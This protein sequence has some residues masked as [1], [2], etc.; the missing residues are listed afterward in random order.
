[1]PRTPTRATRAPA[2]TAGTEARLHAASVR[3]G[4]GAAIGVALHTLPLLLTLLLLP[5]L[6]ALAQSAAWIGSSGTK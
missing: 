3:A 4:A 2:S 6:P 5:A 1:M